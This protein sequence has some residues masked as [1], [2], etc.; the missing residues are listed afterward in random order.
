MDTLRKQEKERLQHS[1]SLPLALRILGTQAEHGSMVGRRR[2]S[3]SRHVGAVKEE[4]ATARLM[5]RLVTRDLLS[6]AGACLPISR[7][8]QNSTTGCRPIKGRFPIQTIRDDE[9]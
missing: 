7:A 9:P 5:S 1:S 4:R 8:S 3:I 2:L 6:L